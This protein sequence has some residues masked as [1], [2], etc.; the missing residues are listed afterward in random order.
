MARAAITKMS[1]DKYVLRPVRDAPPVTLPVFIYGTAWKKDQSSD[2]VLQALTAGFRAVDT[3]AQPKHYREDL[4]GD[5]IRRA[6]RDGTVRREDLHVQTKF[7]SI[8]GQNPD[9]MPYDA[10][11]S[12]TDQV[13]ASISSS[14]N[15]L[16]PL[17]DPNSVKDAYIDLLILH[18]PLPTMTQTLEAWSTLETYV[19]HRIRNLG[20]SN[21]TLPVLRELSSLV[22]VKP[23]AVQNRFY[24]A[25]QFDVPMRAFCRD[26]RIVYQSFWTLTANPELLRSDAVQELASHVG[27]SPAASLYCLVLGLGET[28]M[29]NGTTNRARME[30]DL[31]APR[32]VEQFSRE[33]PDVVTQAVMSPQGMSRKRPA[34]GTSPIVHNPQL[35]QISNFAPTTN[36]HL[37]NDQF[38]QWGQTQPPSTINPSSF[39][40]TNAYNPNAYPSTQDVPTPTA[41][42][43]TQLARR[44]TPNQM[45]NRN[46]GYEQ[47]PTGFS[48]PGSSNSGEAG[49]GESLDELYQRALVA[50]RESQ[51]K[52]KQIPPFVQK[53][54]SFLD[55]SKNTELIRWSDDGNSFIVMDEDEFAKTLIPEL[56]KHNNYASFV[57]QLN[58]YGFHKKVGLSDNS[59]RA[60]E[61]KNKSPSEYANPYFKRG[62][63]DLLWLIQKPKNSVGQGPKPGKPSVRVKTEDAEDHEH[64]EYDDGA[65]ASRDER[66]RN[67]QL[68]LVTGSPIPKDQ[69][70]GVYRE[71]QAIR[72][73]QQIISNTITKLRREHE[74]LYAQAANFQEQHT[75]HENS[76]NAILT[77]LATVYNRSLQ[78]QEGPQNLAN[79]F[80]GA[81]SQDQGNVVDVGDNFSLG[82]LGG[83]NLTSPTGQRT[84]KKHP[85]LLK[86]PPATD[87]HMRATTLS[88]ATTTY[89]HTPSR[90]HTRQPSA[91]QHGHVE[92]VF[93]NSPRPKEA[94]PPQNQDFPQRDIMSVIQNSNARNGIPTSFADF[95]N[96]LSSL[97]NSGGNVPLTP[98]QRADMLRLMASETSPG[99]SNVPPSQNNALISPNPPP[100]PPNYSG[101]L[102]NTRAEMENLM[103]MQAEQDRSVQNLTNLLQPLSPTG[104][105][106]GVGPEGSVPPPPLDLDQIFTSDYFTDIADLEHNKHNLHYGDSGTSAPAPTEPPV[107]TGAD[108]PTIKD[109]NE[110][111]DFDHI[112]DSELFEG[113]NHHHQ[114]NSGLYGFDGAGYGGHTGN[115][116][117]GADP[118]YPDSGRI[119][120]TFTDSESTSPSNPVDEP[121]HYGGLSGH[122]PLGG[123]GPI[124]GGGG[125]SKRRKKA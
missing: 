24:V 107:N 101:Q 67:R 72:Q 32:K 33:H 77:F 3:A 82:A 45:A 122:D 14:L 102:A 120:E 44:Q 108:D 4:V 92:E 89:D 19:P 91:T 88:P 1:W 111:L 68:S 53:L 80:A 79:S 13:H 93:D 71:L 43:S 119:I 83:S 59:M 5:G 118:Q 94:Q 109:P 96:V 51:A 57:R 18:S 60:S 46:R 38:L 27:I 117:T 74:Q 16:R 64:D 52:R 78:G 121:Q 6:I 11:A 37:S 90:G 98:N 112:P 50:K 113:P 22:K 26:N 28:T 110:F 76:I 103:K 10:Q 125:G 86:A 41:T 123:K 124:G 55:E 9:N 7:T 23:A 8:N 12:V 63:P 61:R 66:A 87:P 49:W 2:L 62:H 31:V 70:A 20:I 54:S 115:T 40:D 39:P 69:F 85:L 84:M 42:A 75:R 47:T 30:A 15:H 104:T 95:P 116:G 58:M 56:F 29:L 21:C 106:P 48:D 17:D 99:D 97:E 81:I 34:P 36:N 105:I 100:M 114:Q 35:G 65:G 25:T 73:Q